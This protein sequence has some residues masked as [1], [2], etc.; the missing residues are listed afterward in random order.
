MFLVCIFSANAYFFNIE[1]KCRYDV[2]YEGEKAEWI[3]EIY[4]QGK[5][6]IEFTTIEIFN[7]NNSLIAK[8]RIPFQP[9]NSERGDVIYVG[10]DKKVI[11]HLNGTIPSATYENK[12]VYYPCFTNT[13]TNSFII[14]KYGEYEETHCYEENYTIDVAECVVN[15]NCDSD[16]QCLYNYC[17]KLNCD[18]CQYISE[19]DCLDHECCSSED[20]AFNQNCTNNNCV[21]LDCKD[22]QY[23]ENR[24]CVTLNC[25]E[26]EYILNKNCEKLNCSFDEFALNHSCVLLNCPYNQFI[27]DHMCKNLDCKEDEFAKNHTCERLYCQP[28]ETII[29]HSCAKLRCRL[30]EKIENNT[31]VRD[32]TIIL[33]LLFEVFVIILIIIFLKLDADKYKEEQ[34]NKDHTKK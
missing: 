33:K 8:L 27:E 6:Q 4:N 21:D 7:I 12:L 15:R 22:N 31:C 34:K 17:R 2:C 13:K 24:T 26:D 23:I 32:N 19:H 30:I 9:F 25:R 28:D 3:V 20:C 29:N 16:E 14:A 10:P 11:L 1:A 5:H 18:K